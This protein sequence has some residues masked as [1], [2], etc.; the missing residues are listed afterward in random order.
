VPRAARNNCISLLHLRSG[1]TGALASLL[2]LP[3]STALFTTSLSGGSDEDTDS[4][5]PRVSAVPELPDR[6]LYRLRI[7]TDGLF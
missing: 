1:G 7:R 6:V 5:R 3:G 2:P 4:L